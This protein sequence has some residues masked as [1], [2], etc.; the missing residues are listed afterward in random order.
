[1]TKSADNLCELCLQILFKIL[2]QLIACTRKHEVLPQEKSV[3]ITQIVE[4]VIQIVAAAPDTDAVI[5]CLCRIPDQNF[6]TVA[7]YSLKNVVLRDIVAAHGENTKA[8]HNKVKMSAFLPVL[9]HLRAD[10]RISLLFRERRG[11]HG[12][13]AKS[14]FLLCLIQLFSGCIIDKTYRHCVQILSAVSVRPPELRILYGELA[15]KA[16][17]FLLISCKAG[18]SSIRIRQRNL[19]M[20]AF[21]TNRIRDCRYSKLHLLHDIS[22]NPGLFNLMLLHHSNIIRKSCLLHSKQSDRAIEACIGKARAPVPAEHAVCLPKLRI[23]GHRIRALHILNLLVGGG[24]E[25][26]R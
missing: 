15:A 16:L 13:R 17:L 5:M 21:C 18:R 10:V 22:V 23:A 14:D 8:I 9:S 12:Y 11:V 7:G 4:K 1:M 3:L 26:Q 24:T 25:F 19:C 2:G 20:N 6:R